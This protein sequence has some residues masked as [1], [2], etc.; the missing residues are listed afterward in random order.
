MGLLQKVINGPRP[1]TSHA[2]VVTA[3]GR[4]IVQ[5]RIR[6]GEIL[7]GDQML[8]TRFGVSRTVLREAMKTLA[9]KRLVEPKSKV[10]T[11]VLERE[12]WNFFDS[13]VLSWRLEAGVDANLVAEIAELRMALEPSA[14]ALAARRA[15]AQEVLDL[16]AIVADMEKPDHTPGSIAQVD[17]AFHLAVLRASRNTFMRSMSG[18]IE[19]ALTVSFKLS[20]PAATPAK[21]AELAN[22]HQRIVRRIAARDEAG[23]RSAMEY[24]ITFGAERASRSLASHALT[25]HAVAS[26]LE[27]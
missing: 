21:L 12:Q 16:Y 5:G 25:G 22:N 3:L 14:A 7:P 20:S 1:G 2:L 17:L 19:A 18:V 26:G 27:A 24:V 11:R 10:G 13:D 6:E 23:A 8:T 15:E 4:D 9:A